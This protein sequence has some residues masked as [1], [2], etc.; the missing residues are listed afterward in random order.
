MI[1][2]Q[3]I[4]SGIALIFQKEFN[5]FRELFEQIKKSVENKEDQKQ[6]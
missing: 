4:V 5:E 2:G 3:V 6:N 1:E